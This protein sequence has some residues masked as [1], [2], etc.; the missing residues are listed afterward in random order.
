MGQRGGRART[1]RVSG[2]SAGMPYTSIIPRPSAPV[3]GQGNRSSRADPARGT[4]KLPQATANPRT[5][6]IYMDETGSGGRRSGPCQPTPGEPGGATFSDIVVGGTRMFAGATG[7]LREASS[8]QAQV[9]LAG[10]M[11]LHT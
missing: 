8:G 3:C 4:R 5:G 6:S 9:K 11:A 10:T 7:T 2:A 1:A